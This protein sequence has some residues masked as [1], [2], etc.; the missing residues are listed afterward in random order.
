[1]EPE[2]RNC[3]HCGKS[4]IVP[5]DDPSHANKK[6]CRKNHKHAAKKKRHRERLK[7]EAAM[8]P[9]MVSGNLSVDNPYEKQEVHTRT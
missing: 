9:Y 5:P 6:Y 8:L 2:V 4:F 3:L 7:R 1:M